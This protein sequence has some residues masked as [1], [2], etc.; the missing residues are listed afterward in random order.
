MANNHCFH[1]LINQDHVHLNGANLN[2]LY[3]TYNMYIA[4]LNRTDRQVGALTIYI[5]CISFGQE[6]D[7]HTVQ[8]L[9]NAELELE[10]S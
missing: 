6:H 10:K 9:I 8:T 2:H 3:A 4:V 7:A 1:R 5:P